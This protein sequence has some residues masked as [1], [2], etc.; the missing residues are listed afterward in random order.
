MGAVT[1]GKGT[2][3]GDS[4]LG[5]RER[6]GYDVSRRWGDKQAVVAHGRIQGRG[7]AGTTKGQRQNRHRQAEAGRP[8]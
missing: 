5:Q 8:P 4:A 3:P 1:D 7:W 2:K 6:A